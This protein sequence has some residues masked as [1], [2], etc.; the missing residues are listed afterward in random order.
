MTALGNNGVTMISHPN[1][2]TS[3]LK[4]SPF[5]TDTHHSLTLKGD[6]QLKRK[7]KSKSR[8]CMGHMR[9]GLCYTLDGQLE[10]WSIQ[11]CPEIVKAMVPEGL[12]KLY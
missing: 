3:G 10:L 1:C 6:P 5:Q 8:P 11:N 4:K 2:S 7:Y 9:L 12:I